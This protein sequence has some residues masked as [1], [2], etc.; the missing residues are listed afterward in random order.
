MSISSPLENKS[1]SLKEQSKNESRWEHIRVSERTNLNLVEIQIES[2]CDEI[3]VALRWNLTLVEITWIWSFVSQRTKSSLVENTFESR[4]LKFKSYWNQIHVSLRTNCSLAEN[5]FESDWK[6]MPVISLTNSSP[7]RI[8]F[9]Y[10][11]AS[12]CCRTLTQARRWGWC[13][14]LRR[15]HHGR[16]CYGRRGTLSRRICISTTDWST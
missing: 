8:K 16:A 3:W 5:S 10:L 1:K 2:R 11:P 15:S 9:S 12:T 13:D 14:S 4:R 7:A 6:Q